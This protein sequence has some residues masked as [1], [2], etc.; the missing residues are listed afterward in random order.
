MHKRLLCP[1]LPLPNK[2]TRLSEDEAHHATRVLRLRNGD[3]IEALDG[4][5]Q[6]RLVVLRT[7]EGPVRLE[8]LEESQIETK[9]TASMKIPP[10]ILELGI[11]KNDAMGWV[12]EKAVELGVKTLI[13][14]ITD[15]TVVQIK[16]KG[17]ESFQHRWQKIADQAL[18]QCGRLEQMEIQ[19][20]IA[21][22]TLIL[23]PSQGKRFWCDEAAPGE[24]PFLLDCFKKEP[25]EKNSPQ[26]ILVGPEGGWSKQERQLLGKSPHP[27]QLKRVCLSPQILRA[28]TAAIFAS[29]LILGE[30][31]R[32]TEEKP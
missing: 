3:R 28:E 19:K 4:K 17:P 22:D 2:P 1:L 32:D 15:H 10:V 30:G 5:G 29:A 26:H 18:K 24:A 11:L 25:L 21:L 6:K 23:S 9:P 27:D 20:P 7:N 8:Y 14:V 12:I 31:M 13:P 16:A